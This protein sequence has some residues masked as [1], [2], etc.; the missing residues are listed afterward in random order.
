MARGK[1]E[2][3]ENFGSGLNFILISGYL[4]QSILRREAILFLSG[5]GGESASLSFPTL[6]APSIEDV[7]VF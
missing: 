6:Q 1:A 4:F 5:G 3:L 7:F 2:S